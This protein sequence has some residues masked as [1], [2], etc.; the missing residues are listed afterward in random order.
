MANL[1]SI[2]SGVLASM[3][4]VIGKLSLSQDSL[5]VSTTI[6]FCGKSLPYQY[7]FYVSESVRPSEFNFMPYDA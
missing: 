3:A 5:V 6:W 4:A 7:C 1:K 2:F